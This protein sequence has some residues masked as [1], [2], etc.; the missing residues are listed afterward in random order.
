MG[1]P[2]AWSEARGGSA[3][4]TTIAPTPAGDSINSAD[5]FHAGNRPGGQ[6]PAVRPAETVLLIVVA[7]PRSKYTTGPADL[8]TELGH[9]G[10]RVRADA[11]QDQEPEPPGGDGLRLGECQR[12]ADVV[13]TTGVGQRTMA[14]VSTTIVSLSASR[15]CSSGGMT[16]RSPL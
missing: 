3:P 7:R 14:V 5:R 8:I 16:S 9:D 6:A 11:T 4:F 12:T 2:P 13:R 15:E 1:S 10:S